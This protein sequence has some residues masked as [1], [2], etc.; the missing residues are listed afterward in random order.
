[1]NSA[2]VFF[3]PY[4]RPLFC[5]FFSLCKIFLLSLSPN[6][7]WTLFPFAFLFL[8]S[9]NFSGVALS[10]F[11]PQLMAGSNGLLCAELWQQQKL[12]FAVSFFP[13]FSCVLTIIHFLTQD[14]EVILK[15][16][17]QWMEINSETHHRQGLSE[18]E[19]EGDSTVGS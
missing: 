4:R 17:G 12:M 19:R 2:K 18:R 5:S 3:S 16:K 7:F 14:G 6:C 8:F 11:L 1:M 15:I 10:F 13:L 9:C